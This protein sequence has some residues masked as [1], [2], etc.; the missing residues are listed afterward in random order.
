MVVETSW[1]HTVIK[2]PGRPSRPPRMTR[3]EPLPDAQSRFQA[4]LQEVEHDLARL[5]GARERMAQ[6]G[7]QAH[8]LCEDL[9]AESTT[10]SSNDGLASV[11]CGGTGKVQRVVLDGSSY[12]QASAQQVCDSV[13]QA[14]DLARDAARAEASSLAA[15][16]LDT[17]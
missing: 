2:P 11:T 8:Q 10:Q 13:L 17:K 9:G 12:R 5:R 7:K 14:R 16:P 3:E 15:I 1:W 4:K 6:V